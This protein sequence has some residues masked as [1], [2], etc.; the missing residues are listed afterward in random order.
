L[1]ERGSKNQIRCL[2][3]RTNLKHLHLFDSFFPH[4]EDTLVGYQWNLYHIQG[5]DGIWFSGAAASFESVEAI[6][7]YNHLILGNVQNSAAEYCDYRGEPITP[8]AATDNSH[9]HGSH[10]N[11][12]LGRISTNLITSCL[13]IVKI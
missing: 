3:Y 8:Y 5:R 4:W 9:H 10:H 13:Y 2:S 11:H 1:P 12:H 7:D 6:F